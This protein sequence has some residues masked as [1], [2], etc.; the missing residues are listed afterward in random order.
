MPTLAAENRGKIEIYYEE[1]GSGEPLV[2]IG[3]FTATVEVWG[4]LRPLLAEKFR[5]IMP[6]NRGSGRTKVIGGDGDRAPGRFAGDVFALLGG[7]GIGRAHILGGSMG[8]MIAQEFALEHPERTRSLVIACS[9]FGGADKVSAAPGVREKRLRG[10]VPGAT[11][12]EKR[13]ALETIFHPDTIDNRP[14]VVEFYDRNKQAFP[15]GRE[16]LEARTE[17]MAG[18]D[19]SRRLPSLSV[20]ALVI[21]GESDVLVPTE[22]SRLIAERIPGAELAIVEGAGHHFYSER[23]EESA[24]II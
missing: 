5:V 17:G 22:N 9:H 3:G 19:A 2:L 1:E 16:E 7:L 21:A 15:H 8:G 12:A 6:D 14:E 11:E 20:P 18:F 4:R 10:G 13:A 24:R 23:P